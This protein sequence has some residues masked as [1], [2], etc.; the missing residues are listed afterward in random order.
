M[1]CNDL[2][3][4]YSNYKL[5]LKGPRRNIR[6]GGSLYKGFMYV[7]SPCRTVSTTTVTH[8]TVL[9]P[10]KTESPCSSLSQLLSLQFLRIILLHILQSTA[11][12]CVRMWK[13]KEVT[14]KRIFFPLDVL[15][16]QIMS[17]FKSNGMSV[18]SE[19]KTCPL[20]RLLSLV[21]V[22]KISRLSGYQPWKFHP[23]PY[24]CK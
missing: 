9:N 15:L 2:R 4:N 17:L 8:F 7:Y 10:G 5:L 18:V 3:A 24:C 20:P 1:W 11:S 21:G 12:N 14:S 19:S 6:A 23:S 16:C 22:L 13:N